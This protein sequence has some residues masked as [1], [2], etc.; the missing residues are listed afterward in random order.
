VKLG[1]R[2]AI[3]LGLGAA[4][5]L[6]M[7]GCESLEQRFTKPELPKSAWAP[8]S[9]A[10]PEARLLNRIGFGPNPSD[11]AAVRSMGIPA[12][13]SQQLKPES[14]AE[15]AVLT[16]RVRSLNDILSADAGILF[17]IDDRVAVATLRAATILRAVYSRRQLFERM[18][19]F[20]TDHFN[21]YEGKG[22][23]PQ[24]KIIDDRETIR[25]F[26][27]GKFRDLLG[28]SARSAAMLGYL[29]NRINEKRHP[30]ENYA[31]EIMEL[32]TLG[33]NGGYTQ[34][35]VM[36]VARCLTGWTTQAHWHRSGFNFDESMHDDG[37]KTVLG[38][39]I[40]PGGGIRDGEHVLDLLAAHPATAA[41]ISRK[42]CHFFLG[43]AGDSMIDAVA[44]EF[45]R[46]DGDIKATLLPILHCPLLMS[47]PPLYKRPFDYIVSALRSVNADTDGGPSM[48]TCLE[49]LGQ[50][51]FGWPRPDGFPEKPQPW[52]G[53]LLG[54]WNV[55]LQLTSGQINNTHV[56]LDALIASVGSKGLN[57]TDILSNIIL[58][59]DGTSASGTLSPSDAVRPTAEQAALLLMSPSFQYR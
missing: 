38:V 27:F 11:L 54:R 14:I 4:V 56:D 37:S 19:N 49:Q 50:P 6:S 20:W 32:H 59:G 48:Q 2:E 5:G 7:T 9:L 53:N 13:I 26:A 1:R 43:D 22:E 30:N 46:T 35:D 23:G 3:Q 12:Y 25:K 8:A 17:D 18:V 28:A 44:A 33:V 47:A 57:P 31:R 36:E 55:A 24:L 51:L 29:D 42:L 40:P 45:K 34:H 58:G 21:I 15:P 16:Y 39:V 52:M 10:S 41:H